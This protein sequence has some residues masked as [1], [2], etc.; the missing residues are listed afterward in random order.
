MPDP[1]IRWLGRY[2]GLTDKFTNGTTSPGD[3]MGGGP[4]DIA[5]HFMELHSSRI[6]G[7]DSRNRHH[8]PSK[9]YLQSEELKVEDVISYLERLRERVERVAPPSRRTQETQTVPAALLPV[10]ST[11]LLQELPSAPAPQ[12][13]H[14]VCL[15]S[16]LLV[17]C[18][19]F[20]FK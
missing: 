13:L 5:E 14:Q 19:I 7:D 20:E 2:S 9:D 8:S 15:R 4:R 6:L 10:T 11:F 3:L 1:V 12:H 17:K 18:E 16:W